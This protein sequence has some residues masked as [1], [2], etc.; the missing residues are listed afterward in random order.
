M[1]EHGDLACTT[2]WW[3]PG[4]KGGPDARLEDVLG[5]AALASGDPKGTLEKLILSSKTKS[6]KAELEGMGE[7][8]LHDKA[9]NLGIA[10]DDDSDHSNLEG[11]I[12]AK[13]QEDLLDDL[14]KLDLQGLKGAAVGRFTSRFTFASQRLTI[15]HL[16][17]NTE[18]FA[19]DSGCKRKWW[20]HGRNGGGSCCSCR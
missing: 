7:H 20:R 13:M 11:L 1:L 4:S 15:D 2:E 10:L 8:E 19:C 3:Q 16:H 9:R 18:A 5:R 17:L 12:L 6:F 14:R